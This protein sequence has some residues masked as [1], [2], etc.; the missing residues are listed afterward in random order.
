MYDES[1]PNVALVPLFDQGQNIWENV[2]KLNI[3]L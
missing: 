1:T 2:E 3:T